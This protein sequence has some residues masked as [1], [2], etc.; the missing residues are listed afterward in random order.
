[1]ESSPS[2]IYSDNTP[3]PATCDVAVRIKPLGAGAGDLVAFEEKYSNWRYHGCDLEKKSI[4][5]GDADP[6]KK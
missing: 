3:V 6:K 4:R 2:D 1:M 5:F